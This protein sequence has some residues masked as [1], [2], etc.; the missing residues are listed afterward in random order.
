MKI[1]KRIPTIMDRL[2][3]DIEKAGGESQVEYVE[4]DPAEVLE[5]L[6]Y[7]PQVLDME[8][9]AKAISSQAKTIS[10]INCRWVNVRVEQYLMDKD[11]ALYRR[12]Y[13]SNEPKS[14]AK[15]SKARLASSGKP[16]TDGSR[17]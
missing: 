8:S 16:L 9:L 10:G 1:H 15:K 12:L 5:F 17:K 3:A 4:L 13:P 7:C 11:P 6:K 14:A 2:R